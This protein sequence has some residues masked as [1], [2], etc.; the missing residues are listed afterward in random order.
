M[1][2]INSAEKYNTLY[3][4]SVEDPEGFWAEVASDFSWHEQWSK[5]LSWDFNKPEVK[6]FEGGKLNITENC[7]DRHLDKRGDQ[8]AIIWEPNEP[9]EPAIHITYR[10]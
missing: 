8:T 5:V 4:K 7:I 6:W 9:A 3:N 1:E 2:N 10:Q